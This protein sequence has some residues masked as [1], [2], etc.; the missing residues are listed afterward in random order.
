[1]LDKT[2]VG[3]RLK[4]VEQGPPLRNAS[5]SFLPER[6][7]GVAQPFVPVAWNGRY[8]KF[9]D[10]EPYDRGQ[11]HRS[12]WN[13]QLAERVG[14]KWPR[15]IEDARLDM[16]MGIRSLARTGSFRCPMECQQLRFIGKREL[17]PV[18]GDFNVQ[19]LV[20]ASR[21]LNDAEFL[22][23]GEGKRLVTNQA[24]RIVSVQENRVDGIELERT[25]V[26]TDDSCLGQA[27]EELLK[28]LKVPAERRLKGRSRHA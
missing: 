1:M 12:R 15:G 16:K 11:R 22:A 17:I 27:A 25:P 21:S 26:R 20:A 13:V 3:Q 4:A 14:K 10:G 7:F 28:V 9:F 19:Q 2:G 23:A 8:P 24:H 5:C 6:R 18:F